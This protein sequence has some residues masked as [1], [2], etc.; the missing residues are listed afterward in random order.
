MYEFHIAHDDEP[1]VDLSPEQIARFRDTSADYTSVSLIAWGEHCT[2]C[3]WPE[4]YT[5]CDLYEARIDGHCRRFV[6]GMVPRRDVETVT[7]WGVEIAFKRWGKLMATSSAALVPVP[8]ARAAVR[9]AQVLDGVADRFASVRFAGREHATVRLQGRL[10]AAMSRRGSTS[11]DGRPDRVPDYFLIEIHSTEAEVVPLTLTLRDA[12]TTDSPGFHELLEVA[13]GF[14]RYRVPYDSIRRVLGAPD[15]LEIEVVPNI[16]DPEDEGLTLV[17]GSL[18]FVTDAN[19]QP[20]PHVKAVIWDLDNTLWDGV[21]VED[22]PEGIRLRSEVVDTIRTLD[23]RGVVN[24]I[25]SKNGHDEAMEMLASFG[26]D[27]LFVFP[28]ISWE[29]KS[30]GVARVIE[31]L[32]VGADTIAFVDDQPF[33]RAEV[34]EAH[35]EV[36]LVD[37]SV[38]IDLARRP[39]FDPPVSAESRHRRRSYQNQ[40]R[41]DEALHTSAGDYEAFLR[42]C[43]IEVRL[44]DAREHEDR[45]HELIQRTNQMNFSGHR[46]SRAEISELLGRSA[47]DCYAVEVQD[48]FGSYGTVGFAAVDRS[49]ADPTVVDLAFSC[50]V[51][52]KRVEHGVLAHLMGRY[53]G[54]GANRFLVHYRPTA[55]NGPSAR[56]FDDLGFELISDDG[57]TCVLGFDISTSA[58]QVEL[59]KVV[60]TT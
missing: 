36:R 59:V 60:D 46:Y 34:G 18:Q 3:A 23:G 11:A 54:E 56:V 13:P 6:S 7:G 24:S 37:G 16:N 32:N 49:N 47:T 44:N 10:K 48:R 39:E 4:C 15:R 5:T 42:D 8:A 1:R 51:Q 26:I 20:P 41:R 30:L 29:P 28:E 17:F 25:V 58:P 50:R 14:N 43:A 33:E 55:K 52:S 9:S 57:D 35:P 31:R 40:E 19:W 12:A 38:P 45:V 27:D 2:E 53:R 21:L 22:G